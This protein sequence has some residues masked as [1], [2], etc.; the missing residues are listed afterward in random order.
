MQKNE[1][2]ANC[3][4]CGTTIIIP[5]QAEVEDSDII[6]IIKHPAST[7]AQNTI[8]EIESK[9]TGVAHK[10]QDASPMQANIEK[11]SDKNNNS[12]KQNDKILI[13]D[14]QT[15][16]VGKNIK[17]NKQTV[18]VCFDDHKSQKDNQNYIEREKS[19][20]ETQN[21]NKDNQ[22]DF[23][24]GNGKSNAAI[25]NLS[26]IQNFFGMQVLKNELGD[27]KVN[28]TKDK[29][30][31][32]NIGFDNKCPAEQYKCENSFFSGR[33]PKFHSPNYCDPTIE[34]FLTLIQIYEP[35]FEWLRANPPKY[36]CFENVLLKHYTTIKKSDSES[37]DIDSVAL[38]IHI[39]LRGRSCSLFTRDEK[40]V[41]H[42]LMWFLGCF[43]KVLI[44]RESQP[45]RSNLIFPEIRRKI[46]DESGCEYYVRQ[47]SPIQHCYLSSEHDSIHDLLTESLHLSESVE[48]WPL[49]WYNKL[50]GPEFIYGKYITLNM[51]WYGG[52]GEGGA[53][54]NEKLRNLLPFSFDNKRG[55]KYKL[56]VVVIQ[57]MSL[58]DLGISGTKWSYQVKNSRFYIVTGDS[59][60]LEI[61]T[62]IV[63]ENIR[64]GDVIAVYETIDE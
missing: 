23:E 35:L 32:T 22:N 1:K 6:S 64:K 41:K 11:P 8:G 5:K 26:D 39:C 16:D 42:L 28:S 61:P 46:R 48:S 37:I 2:K 60:D 45:N 13:G 34:V 21:P 58:Y 54:S 51:P 27:D 43:E 24:R 12:Q 14:A 56:K 59:H 36:D 62:Y 17:Q 4:N 18:N 31:R 44:S 55:K 57:K 63:Y 47:I 50:E 40:H 7:K 10:K 53:I 29:Q 52:S 33:T 3:K 38:N 15:K 19:K 25:Q 30:G 9:T 20:F 49:P